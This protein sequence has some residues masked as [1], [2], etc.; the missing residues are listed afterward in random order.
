MRVITGDDIGYF[1]IV[2]LNNDLLKKS[3]GDK[4]DNQK[5]G[6]A[7]EKKDPVRIQSLGEAG[8]GKSILFMDWWSIDLNQVIHSSLSGGIQLTEIVSGNVIGKHQLEPSARCIG[9][10][11]VDNQRAYIGL[12]NSSVSVI[13]FEAGSSEFNL[14]TQKTIVQ[15]CKDSVLRM[16]VNPQISSNIAIGGKEIGLQ[17]W[18]IESQSH[19]YKFKNVPHDMLNLRQPIWIKDI[20]YFPK[21]TS[22]LLTGTGHHQVRLYDV[23]HRNKRPVLDRVLGEHPIV[24]VAVS[25]DENYAIAADGIGT[26][27][28]LDVR[29]NFMEIGKYKGCTGSVRDVKF[30]PSEPWLFTC[31]LDRYLRVFDVESRSLKAK[32]YLKQKLNC[33][34]LANSSDDISGSKE[35]SQIPDVDRLWEKIDSIEKSNLGTKRTFADGESGSEPEEDDEDDEVDEAILNKKIKL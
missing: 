18:D 29:K 8:A 14:V 17:I 34:L 11:V 27:Y 9:L 30:H 19:V 6:E 7:S 35:E 15:G 32:V 33:I 4:N 3:K 20:Q 26:V 31:G 24:S 5:K 23:N 13:S 22:K 12:S 2:D 10:S 25:P 21:S 1:K 16:R 28:K